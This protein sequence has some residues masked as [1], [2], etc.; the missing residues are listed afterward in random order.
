MPEPAP[1]PGP[2]DAD[3]LE[4][5]RTGDAA[6][7][8]QLY[9]RHLAAARSLARQLVRGAQ[10]A[11][12]VTADAFARVLDLLRRGGGPRDGFRP[13]LLTAVR[14]L[15]YDRYR[16]ERRA[17]ATGAVEELDP[18]Q[19][20]TDPAVEG[21]ERSLIARAFLSLPERWRAVLWH[22]E[23][24]GAK[25]ADVAPL[26]GLTANGVAALSYRAREGLRQA[27]LQ[28]HLS[29][30]AR[31]GCQPT[32]AKLG[33]YVRG[34]LSRRDSDSVEAHLARCGDCRAVYAELTDVNTSLR[35]V[36]APIFLGP[37]A[38]GYLAAVK[39][40]AGWLAWPVHWLR[41]APKQVQAAA[42]GGLVAAAA[43]AAVLGGVFSGPHGPQVRHRHSAIGRPGPTA[44]PAPQRG[45]PSAP[46]HPPGS[47]ARPGPGSPGAAQPGGSP[48][49]PTGAQP[50]PQ[51][52]AAGASPVQ[53]APGGSGGTS[54]G[55]SGNG[56]GVP[57]PGAPA[58]PPAPPPTPPPA[59][60]PP[61]APSPGPALNVSVAASAPVA[62]AGVSAG[63]SGGSLG[64][65]AGLAS[66]LIQ[67]PG[68]CPPTSVS[69]SLSGRP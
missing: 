15:A 14:R 8:G 29:S 47:P 28:M 27:Y 41:H 44:P 68:S 4:A 32:L 7:Y 11:D 16:G 36:V 37:A 5:V 40:G 39:G 26:L 42:A 23:I 43:L 1:V 63:V 54:G 56:G 2:S 34:G 45:T 61:P 35:G 60:P 31:P 66:D 17:V 10:D 20:F 22:T 38:A 46:H 30:A 6:A 59:P 57:L 33:A 48:G 25:P 12:D 51:T 69:V 52:A 49:S 24:E 50:G 62:C 65:S 13:Y 19:P 55:G 58:P 18:G 21:L 64:L 67:G 53:P 3:L 9:E